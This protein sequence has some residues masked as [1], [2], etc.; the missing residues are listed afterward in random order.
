M[1]DSRRQKIV[2]AIVT[3][4]MLINGSG[5]YETNLADRVK[6]S[7]SNWAEDQATLPA[8]SVFDGDAEAVPTSEGRY[9]GTVHEM[10]VLIKGYCKQGTTAANARKLIKD[11]NTAIRV[12]DKWLVSGKPLVMQTREKREGITRTPDSFEVEGCEV[13]IEV[14]YITGKFN[15]E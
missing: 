9:R 15:A 7:E 8:V 3:R 13:E 11:I 1:V 14:T 4:M 2:D 6:D 5:D 10:P 12:D